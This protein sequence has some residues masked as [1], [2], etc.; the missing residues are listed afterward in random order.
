MSP[1]L[2]E[3]PTQLAPFVTQICTK[4][5][6]GNHTN[7]PHMDCVITGRPCCIGTKGRWVCLRAEQGPESH[8]IARAW[9][10][11]GDLC[12]PLGSGCPPLQGF[13]TLTRPSRC[14]ITSREY[15][16][17]MRGYFHEEAT[18]CSQVGVQ[19]LVPPCPTS[20]AGADRPLCAGALYG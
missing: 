9:G 5:S 4:N 17:F 12:L 11:I 10:A 20:W 7:H 8:E 15:C 6:A 18:L 19:V 2:G 1:G 16:D 14:E 3:A 13:P